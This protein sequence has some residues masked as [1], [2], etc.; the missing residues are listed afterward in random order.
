MCWLYLSKAEVC[1]SGVG[2]AVGAGKDFVYTYPS[3]Q[4]PRTQWNNSEVY[5]L[6]QLHDFSGSFKPQFPTGSRKFPDNTSCIHCLHFPVLLHHFPT[7]VFWDNFPKIYLVFG[8]GPAFGGKMLNQDP[9]TVSIILFLH[10]FILY[11][12]DVILHLQTRQPDN[13]LAP[14]SWIPTRLRIRL[15]I[16]SNIYT[17]KAWFH[18]QYSFLLL[19]IYLPRQIG[20]LYWYANDS[21]VY[22]SRP[23]LSLCV[24]TCVLNGLLVTWIYL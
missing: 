5:V 15:S 9:A 21:W 22:V 20:L 19:Y 6:R 2:G 17:K 12:S 16:R 4:L 10:M 3:S 8:P 11:L 1:V 14:A 24:W 18:R 7:C 13:I 23:E